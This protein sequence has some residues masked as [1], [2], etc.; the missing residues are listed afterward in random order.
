MHKTQHF[1]IVI[2]FLTLG[3]IN[4]AQANQLVNGSFDDL[5]IDDNSYTNVLE[6]TPGL[7]W[8]TTASDNKIEIWRQPFLGVNAYDGA[9][10]A[11]LNANEVANLYQDVVGIAAGQYIGW[12][13][14]HRGRSGEDTM[15]L[16]IIDLG[17]D[18]AAGGD[19]DTV[20]FSNYNFKDGNSAWSF[21]EGLTSILS[22]GNT[23]RFNFLSL[24]SA[25]SDDPET[26]GNFLD[27][28][29]FGVEEGPDP[30]PEPATMFLF[31]SGIAALAGLRLKR[32]K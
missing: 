14:A 5:V 3:C 19:A 4:N 17:L 16:E 7:G 24:S 20:L 2:S 31:G 29:A 6:G 1:V 28:V 22:L 21:Y 9:Q 8:Q 13:F 18:N 11:E 25:Q 30:V 27:A 23:V 26:Y 12:E 15:G 32:K 10:F